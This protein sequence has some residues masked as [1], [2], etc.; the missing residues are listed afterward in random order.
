MNQKINGSPAKLCSVFPW[1]ALTYT[2][3]GMTES[4][5]QSEKKT[6]IK[7][8]S[9]ENMHVNKNRL[10]VCLAIRFFFWL[11]SRVCDRA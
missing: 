6:C 9:K 1:A 5:Q 11:N 3:E 2:E 10:F 7:A 8:L 4:L